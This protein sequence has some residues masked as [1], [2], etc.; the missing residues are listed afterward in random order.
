V[1]WWIKED[2]V[3]INEKREQGK[4]LSD[5]P[6]IKGIGPGMSEILGK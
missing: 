4:G 6:T 2:G 1:I 3:R 5:D